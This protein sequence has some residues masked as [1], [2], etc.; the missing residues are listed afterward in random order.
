MCRLKASRFW[1]LCVFAPLSK[2]LHYLK[3]FWEDD[4]TQQDIAFD[5]GIAHF[6]NQ[7]LPIPIGMKETFQARSNYSHKVKGCRGGVQYEVRCGGVGHASP[8]TSAAFELTH[9]SSFILRLPALCI[10]LYYST[11]LLCYGVLI[12][13]GYYHHPHIFR[14]HQ[15]V[16]VD[17][18]AG[19]VSAHERSALIICRGKTTETPPEFQLQPTLLLRGRHDHPCRP[20]GLRDQSENLV[21]WYRGKRAGRQSRL[22]WCEA[23]GAR[24]QR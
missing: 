18:S 5:T 1:L 15:D 21:M 12:S 3:L 17:S 7:A 13:V 20:R 23:Q 24:F 8:S 19:V 4:L 11:A 2:T 14:V 6:F 22:V 16:R 10:L 9:S